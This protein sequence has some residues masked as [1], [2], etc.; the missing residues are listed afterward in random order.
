M[1][2]ILYTSPTS[3]GVMGVTH[4][5]VKELQVT[6]NIVILFSHAPKIIV[7]WKEDSNPTEIQ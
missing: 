4:G 7:T 6:T 1:V 2:S 3:Q 5:I